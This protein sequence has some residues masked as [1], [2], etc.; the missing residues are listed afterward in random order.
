MYLLRWKFEYHD[1]KPTKSGIWSRPAVNL[2]DMAAM[3][4]KENLR[5]ASIEAKHVETRAITTLA[6]CDGYDFINFEW[7]A[8]AR[9]PFGGGE[10]VVRLLG[11]KLV[12]RE[13][14]IHVYPSGDVKILA[15]AE[16]DKNF[17]YEGFG[18]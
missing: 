8:E 17:H 9:T 5:T 3:N 14:S 7:M 12:T 10:T 4:S 15:R 1:S 13:T 18:R 16:H 6:E 2:A 11:I